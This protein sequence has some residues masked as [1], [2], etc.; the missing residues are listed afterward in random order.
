MEFLANLTCLIGVTAPYM[1]IKQVRKRM[2]EPNLHG[3]FNIEG[4]LFLVRKSLTSMFE[5]LPFLLQPPYDAAAD[6]YEDIPEALEHVPRVILDRR[7]T[8]LLALLPSDAVCVC[9]F[10]IAYTLGIET[11]SISRG[12]RVCFA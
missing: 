3:Y 2:A 11:S 5:L 1:C 12:W 9:V 10:S 6:G 8:S 7:S 4:K